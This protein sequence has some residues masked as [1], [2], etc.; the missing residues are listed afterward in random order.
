VHDGRLW[1]DRALTPTLYDKFVANGVHFPNAI[2]ETPLCCP[3]RGTLLTGLH[4]HNHGVKENDVVLFDPSESIATEL[5]S[6]GYET[7]WLGKYMNRP[8]HLT[9]E[10]WQQHTAPWSVFD[11]FVNPYTST[12]GFFFNYTVRTKEGEVLTPDQHSTEFIA[13]R[14]VSRMANADPDKPIFAV[15]S[16]VDTHLPNI[17]MP[18]FQADARCNSMQPWKPPNYN[19]EDVSDKPPY[20]RDLKPVP[21]PT[22]WPMTTMCREMLGVDWM[23]KTVTDE[24]EAQGRLDNTLLVF[25]ADNGMAWGAHRLQ[26]KE[27]PYVTPVPLYFHWPF[28]WGSGPRTIDEHVSNIDLA[29]TFC[30]LADCE[31]GPF[32]T[33]QTGP[34]GV[35]LVP[36][37]FRGA[38]DL[39]RDALLET[40]YRI[41]PWAAVRTTDLNDLGLWHYVDYQGGFRELYNVDP[42]ED[43]WELENL[44]Y[45]PEYENIRAALHE[46]LLELLAEG[47]TGGP[48]TLTIT[49]DSLPNA[50]DDFTFTGDLGTFVLDDDGT[51]TLPRKRVFTGLTPGPYTLTQQP[52]SGSSLMS[53]TCPPGNEIDLTS[54]TATV[55]LLP[56]DEVTCTFKNAGRRPDARIAITATGTFKGANVYATTPL[57][58]QT[59]RWDGAPAGES[60]DFVV[61]LQ[62]DSRLVDSFTVRGDETSSSHIAVK[63]FVNDVEVSSAV[64]A[65]T[66]SIPDLATGASVMMTV[67][68]SVAPDAPTSIKRK[69]V[70]SQRSTSVTSRVDVVRAVITR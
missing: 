66:Y 5:Q 1:S 16:V 2:A 70:I 63:Y 49:Q 65:G 20:V 62:N 50:G 19:E 9:P 35:S 28:R 56:G 41:R 18:Q 45:D 54:G 44:A 47:R 43:P 57:K 38:N 7:M 21:Y 23:V 26:L 61:G 64:R 39:G 55:H 10:L 69:I 12:E 33:G 27:T 34:D 14:A 58:A 3:S 48:A 36:L 31:M 6:V 29:P 24:L 13:Q 11:V 15:L 22:G 32:A 52:T 40:E 30:A 51:V 17:P 67:R 59:Q 4:T 46:R 68:V 53:I 42:D 25:T 60:L 37:M 8:E